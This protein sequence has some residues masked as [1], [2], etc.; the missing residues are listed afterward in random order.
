MLGAGD[1]GAFVG[2]A[3]FPDHVVEG[4]AVYG[5]AGGRDLDA[6]FVAADEGAQVGGFA[7]RDGDDYT[8]VGEKGG[9]RDAGGGEGFFVGLVA[10]KKV[11]REKDDAGGIGVGKVDGAGV[12]ENHGTGMK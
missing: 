5:E 11:A 4:E 9:E 2:G 1:G 12:V 10:D 6:E 3:G 8:V 7:I